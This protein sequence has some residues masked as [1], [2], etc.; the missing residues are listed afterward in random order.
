MITGLFGAG[1][2]SCG[3]DAS[4]DDVE[5]TSAPLVA[6]GL[7]AQYYDGRDFTALKLT[8]VDPTV[9]FQWGAGSPDPSIGADTFSVRWDGF[10]EPS[11]SETYRFYVT[12][13][14]GVRLWVDGKLLVDNWTDHAATENSGTI[15]L[16]AG[17]RYDIRMEF[18][19]NGGD[20]TAT[21]SW[22]SPSVSKRIVPST[23]LFPAT[24]GGG[25]TSAAPTLRDK[26]VATSHNVSTLTIGKPPATQPGDL[27]VAIVGHDNGSQYG[28]ATPAGWTAVPNTNVAATDWDAHSYAFYRMAGASE[29]S[30]YAFRASSGYG[31]DM[32]GGIFAVSGAD[33][34]RPIHASGAKAHTS[35]G[36]PDCPTPSLTTTVAN[37]LL[38]YGCTATNTTTAYG[39]PAGMTEAWDRVSGNT[40]YIYPMTTEGASRVQSAAGA[41]GSPSAVAT[42]GHPTSV[43]TLIAIAPASTSTG[44][45]DTKP[46][47]APANFVKT[48]ATAT[49][50]DTS[51]TASTD[52]VGVAGYRLYEGTKLV[53]SA[54]G[55]TASIG[56]LACGTTFA[57]GVEAIDAAGNTSPRTTLSASTAACSTPSGGTGNRP[58]AASSSWNALIPSNAT[59]ASLNWPAPTGY[60]YGVAW[61]SY[62][63]AI[64][65]GASVDPLVRVSVPASW[66]WP[67][68]TVSVHLP[69]GATGANG[70]DGEILMIEGTTVHNCWQFKRTSTTTASCAAYGR[71]DIVTGSG[72]GSK[73]PFLGAGIVATGSSQLAGLLVQAET[74]AGEIEHALQITLDFPLQKPGAVGEAI[75]S[76]GGSQTGIAQEGERLAIPT[77]TAMPS[78]LSPLGQKVFRCMQRYGVY[79]IDVSGGTSN[80]RAQANAYSASVIVALQ[81]DVDKLIPKLQKV[82]F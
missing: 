82:H 2:V 19:E 24:V 46:P 45:G 65:A 6:G 16:T 67:A 59:Y 23:R 80:L 8:R 71:T 27:L 54:S 47:T 31:W 60:N 39:A 11:G 75:A 55:T 7:R 15:T 32:T 26:S 58:F 33:P 9:D 42:S 56:S 53:A 78:G 18:Y 40:S 44:S 63:P 36:A 17:V 14:D 70:T 13:D 38:L 74:D 72:W 5:S 76:D 81:A 34:V 73:S 20:A 49:S 25:A 68:Q 1:T 66:G 21:L 43:G 69:A 3:S 4:E 22:S 35:G 48:G 50:I 57:L 79:D 61:D 51:W 12:S 30:S 52:D 28:I 41:T 10:V 64:F 62:S 77:T 29:P 37:T